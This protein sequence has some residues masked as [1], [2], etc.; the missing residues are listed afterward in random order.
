MRYHLSS[1]LLGFIAFLAV[2]CEALPEPTEPV[3]FLQ[4]QSLPTG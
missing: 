3:V 1:L 2:G 4:K